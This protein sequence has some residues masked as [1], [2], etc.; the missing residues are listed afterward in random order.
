MA[1]LNCIKDDTLISEDCELNSEIIKGKA[2]ECLVAIYSGFKT[3]N[4]IADNLGIP[5]FAVKLYINRLLDNGIIETE[6]T[7]TCDNRKVQYYCVSVKNIEI[8]NR[9]SNDKNSGEN[10]KLISS[11]QHFS[12][13]TRDMILG[14][15]MN[16]DL[17]HKIKANFIRSTPQKMEDFK[18][19]IEALFEK[20]EELEQEE[21]VTCNIYGLV[22]IFAPYN[23]DES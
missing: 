18:K 13:I 4:S 20:Y 21:E 11:A 22:N 5:V 2:L 7:E 14:V 16:G 23:L 10:I 19:E 15:G 9:I 8:I 1:E 12:V 3:V 17:P 6:K